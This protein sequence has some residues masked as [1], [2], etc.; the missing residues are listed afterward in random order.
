MKKEY[1]E[2][3]NLAL[4]SKH[5]DEKVIKLK[6]LWSLIIEESLFQHAQE[7]EVA[8]HIAYILKSSKLKYASF[9]DKVYIDTDHSITVL[10]DV[11]EE[12]ASKLKEDKIDIVALKNAG[13]TKAI[14]KNN[15]CSPMGD[16]DLLVRSKDFRKAHEII[17][18]DLDFTF[19]FRSEFEE[20][21]LEEAFRGGGTEYYKIVDGHKVWL[22]L[23]W[24]PIA[25]RWIQPHNEPDGDNLMDNSIEVENSNIRILAP[26]DNLLQV[27]LHTAKH[28]YVR[29]PGFRLHSDVDRIV[30]FQAIDW[31]KFEEKVC[32]LKIKT[33]VYFSLYFASQ[34]IKTPIPDFILSSLKPS[35]LRK[36]MILQ[37]INKSGIYNQNK[38]KFS[39]IGYIVF[40]LAL[41]DSIG[42][43]IKAIFPSYNSIKIKYPIKNKLQLPYFYFIRI[44]D[45]IFKRAKL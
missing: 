19:K 40:N 11:L 32:N 23:Q 38:K 30:R 41:Y 1:K 33:A 35:W 5:I 3:L 28:S 42:E 10:M 6:Q 34:L 21:D 18:N 31:K 2:I 39:K 17:L 20:E 15:A 37:F 43:N 4:S 8:S 22:E 7:D 44:K 16:L 24:R 45:L 27:A 29:A 25:G 13:I 9:W 14:F 36:K 26:E 12:V